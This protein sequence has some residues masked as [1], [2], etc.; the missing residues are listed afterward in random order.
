[1]IRIQAVPRLAAK[2]LASLPLK[3]GRR[4]PRTAARRSRAKRRLSSEP[5]KPSGLSLGAPVPAL[6]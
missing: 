5:T 3:K 6:G 1:M 4:T 2:L